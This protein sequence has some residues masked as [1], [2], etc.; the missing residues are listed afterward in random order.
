MQEAEDG[1]IVPVA[2]LSCLDGLLSP[3][4]TYKTFLYIQ[5]NP[6]SLDRQCFQLHP[7]ESAQCGGPLVSRP[8]HML[9]GD[10]LTWRRWK[11]AQMGCSKLRQKQN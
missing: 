5:K 8:E 4:R 1:F 7:A 10:A 2:Y 6:S 11:R 3:S 9:S